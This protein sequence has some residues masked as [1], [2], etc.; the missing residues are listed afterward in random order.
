MKMDTFFLV[1]II[2]VVFLGSYGLYL[3]VNSD[4]IRSNELG[5]YRQTPR[6]LE[7]WYVDDSKIA[8][9][10]RNMYYSNIEYVEDEGDKII[11]FTKACEQI[12]LYRDDNHTDEYRNAISLIRKYVNV[13]TPSSEPVMPIAKNTST[14]KDASVVGRALAGGVIAGPVGAVVGALSAVDANNK[15]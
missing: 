9:A 6:A 8:T 4:K 10:T 5:K 12:T 15:K 14:E 11:V 3:K 1:I 7:G 13:K 2:F